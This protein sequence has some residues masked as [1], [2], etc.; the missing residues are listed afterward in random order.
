[1]TLITFC[2]GHGIDF[3]TVI[4]Q[5]LIGRPQDPGIPS[6]GAGVSRFQVRGRTERESQVAVHVRFDSELG[7]V[8]VPSRPNVVEPPAGIAPS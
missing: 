4:G 5:I 6:G 2:D 8:P 3:V 7:A 1:V